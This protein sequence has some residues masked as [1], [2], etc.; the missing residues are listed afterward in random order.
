MHEY[1]SSVRRLELESEALTH[2]AQM[3]H[4]FNFDADEILG[5]GEDHTSRQINEA[6]MSTD[7]S[8]NRHLNLPAPYMDLRTPLTGDRQ[9]VKESALPIISATNEDGVGSSRGKRPADSN[10]ACQRGR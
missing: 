1:Q 7:R 10:T 3:G 5:R 8:V 2:S 6:W 4:V 9:G